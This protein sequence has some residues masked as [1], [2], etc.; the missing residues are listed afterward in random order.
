MKI[1]QKSKNRVGP[2]FLF[3]NPWSWNVSYKPL[4]RGCPTH[5]DEKI[6]FKVVMFLFAIALTVATCGYFR[7]T[8]VS[9]SNILQNN[10]KDFLS[11]STRG[12]FLAKNKVLFALVIW[13]TSGAVWTFASWK[14]CFKFD[15]NLD[16]N[17][18]ASSASAWSWQ[19]AI[20][21]F[22]SWCF[23]WTKANQTDL[24]AVPDPGAGEGVPL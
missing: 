24:H 22:C 17:V 2:S 13:W 9:E 10:S 15:F 18:F 11:I 3:F 5:Q 20:V 23:E 8:W 19:V 12:V 6:K 1:M 16:D 4:S 7:P 14:I 21:F